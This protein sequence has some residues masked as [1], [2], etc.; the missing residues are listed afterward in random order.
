MQELVISLW[1]AKLE[2][3]FHLICSTPTAALFGL[4]AL[5]AML[6]YWL[7]TRPRALM[8]PCDLRHQSEEVEVFILDYKT[9]FVQA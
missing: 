7:A 3:L 5:T 2:K 9:L 8:P 6:A 4:G 1:L